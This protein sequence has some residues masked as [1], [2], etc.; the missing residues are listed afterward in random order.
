M[1]KDMLIDEPAWRSAVEQICLELGWETRVQSTGEYTL[2]IC[3]LPDDKHFSGVFFT[4]SSIAKRLVIYVAYREKASSKYWNAMCEA[5]T[6]INS[7][8]LGGCLELDVEHGEVRYR[9][10]LLL[11]MSEVNIELLRTLVATALRDALGYYPV[12]EA[13]AAGQ[14]PAKAVASIEKE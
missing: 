9:D 13:I 2:I 8:L 5:V 4:V 7:G 11:A 3:P 12:V 14:S 1:K 10:G 6:R